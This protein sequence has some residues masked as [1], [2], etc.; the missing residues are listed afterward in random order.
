MRDTIATLPTPDEVEVT[1]TGVLRQLTE[2]DCRIIELEAENLSLRMKLAVAE[3]ALRFTPEQLNLI[4]RLAI[5]IAEI[6]KVEVSQ[7]AP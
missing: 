3:A 6:L 2:K 1:T 4:K 5:S 7:N